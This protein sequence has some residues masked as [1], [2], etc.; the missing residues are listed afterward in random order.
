MWLGT[1]FLLTL[2]N[3]PK[4]GWGKGWRDEGGMGLDGCGT[5]EEEN[6]SVY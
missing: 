6:E 1:Q 4:L 3:M 2:G 5:G